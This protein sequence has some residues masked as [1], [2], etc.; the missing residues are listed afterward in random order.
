MTATGQLNTMFEADTSTPVLPL[1]EH[2]NCGIQDRGMHRI[3]EIRGLYY[4]CGFLEEHAQ[5]AFIKC[6]D[7][8][9][10]RTDLERRVQHYGWRYDYRTR[11]VT[12]DMDLGPL[13]DWVAD[14][15][16]RLYS[17]TKLF[18]RV[19]DQAIVNEYRPGQGIALHADR[20]CFGDTVATL[21]LGDDWEMRLR[22]VRGTAKEDRRI[23]LARGSVLILTAD[24]RS[25]WMHGI[26]RRRMERSTIGQRERQRRLSLTFRTMLAVAGKGWGANPVNH[27]GFSEARSPEQPHKR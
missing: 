13:P 4:F 9:P 15:A 20:Q 23:M 5:R 7:T 26:D 11:T 2:L 17:E 19:P 21:S 1:P 16:S 24:S 22:P 27:L 18:E 6:I 14:V 12:Q 8:R 25:R 3:P 10:W